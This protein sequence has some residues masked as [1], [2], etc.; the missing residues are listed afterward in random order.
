MNYI[1]WMNQ[2]AQFCLATKLENR[3]Y[4]V[5]VS[6]WVVPLWLFFVALGLYLFIKNKNKGDRQLGIVLGIISAVG[7]IAYIV[8]WNLFC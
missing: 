7:L 5:I 3:F 4:F 6:L 2:A 1:M 8:C